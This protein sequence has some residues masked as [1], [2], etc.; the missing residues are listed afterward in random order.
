MN[1]T[2]LVATIGLLAALVAACLLPVS[3]EG[4]EDEGDG[5]GYVAIPRHTKTPA[6]RPLTWIFLG[7]AAVA[8]AI[9]RDPATVN[10]YV[11]RIR[12]ATQFFA[13]AYIVGLAVVARAS[14]SRRLAI[15][16]HVVLYTAISVLLQAL[17]IVTGMATGWPIAPF[18]IEA[19]LANL[20]VGGLVITRLTFTTYI[21]PPG[22]AAP[23]PPPPPRPLRDRGHAAHPAPRRAGH[24]PSPLH[25]LHPAARAHGPAPS[26]ALGL[27]QRA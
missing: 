14:L 2:L 25:A 13:V 21:L 23:P 16:S 3:A 8:A 7:V 18:G 19:T 15:L 4:T 24:P 17:L 27:G 9:S 10:G 5:K 20:L 11:A 1:I 6:Y 26:P 22:G 12:P